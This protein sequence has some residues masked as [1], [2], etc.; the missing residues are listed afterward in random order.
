M[1]A[2]AAVG[3][4]VVGVT[5][6]IHPTI[7]IGEAGVAGT[8]E[9]ATGT[10]TTE[11]ATDTMDTGKTMLVTTRM[12]HSTGEGREGVANQD[13]NSNQDRGRGVYPA[14][15]HDATTPNKMCLRLFRVHIKMRI[16]FIDIKDLCMNV[17]KKKENN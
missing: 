9:E 2:V 11:G 16:Y 15:F 4:W 14:P 17:S 12:A 10:T 5:T 1:V 6:T 8:G 3:G 7:T 13:H